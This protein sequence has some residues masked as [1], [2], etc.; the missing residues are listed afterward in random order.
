MEIY[1][2]QTVFYRYLHIVL[3]IIRILLCKYICFY[4]NL[5]TSTVQGSVDKNR[6]VIK[7]QVKQEEAK[8]L[9]KLNKVKAGLKQALLFF[10][11][12]YV[13]FLSR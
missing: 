1:L 6:Y 5:C 11:E 4:D 8:T 3:D 2:G 10:K 13:L 12:T 7:Q 9:N